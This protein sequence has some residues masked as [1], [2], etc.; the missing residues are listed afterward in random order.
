MSRNST[1]VC[2][3]RFGDYENKLCEDKRCRAM[4]FQSEN[5]NLYPDN[6]HIVYQ[7]FRRVFVT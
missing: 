3:K 1:I 4:D 5:I 6:I 7:G 2:T